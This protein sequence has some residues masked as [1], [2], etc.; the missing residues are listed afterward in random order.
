MTPSGHH[1]FEFEIRNGIDY[2]RTISEYY[3][4]IKCWSCGHLRSLY[5]SWSVES[6]PLIHLGANLGAQQLITRIIESGVAQLHQTF[7][8]RYNH[9]KY[10]YE[11]HKVEPEKFC[12]AY[13]GIMEDKPGNEF[14]K[15]VRGKE[16]GKCFILSNIY[17]NYWSHSIWDFIHS[18]RFA[19]RWLQSI[20]F[21]RDY[22]KAIKRSSTEHPITLTRSKAWGVP[23]CR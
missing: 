7:H 21:N 16:S 12:K 2:V 14:V 9:A 10:L 4:S 13:T 5:S 1:I 20:A 17:S 22:C 8:F 3:L 23:R 11:F 15:R 18:N 19:G 6:G